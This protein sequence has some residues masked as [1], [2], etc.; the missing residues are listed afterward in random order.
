[1]RKEIWSTR[2]KGKNQDICSELARVRKPVT[3]TVCSALVS[4]G[5]LEALNE[6]KR[7]M[8]VIARR[9][10]PDFTMKEHSNRE[11]TEKLWN[12]LSPEIN[13]RNKRVGVCFNMCIYKR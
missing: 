2:T 12:V 1:M 4:S 3:G 10:F 13:S 7:L 9:A 5:L 8:T 11:I 6:E